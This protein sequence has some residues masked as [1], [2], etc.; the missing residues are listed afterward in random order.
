M[1]IYGPYPPSPG[2]TRWRVQVYD[3]D[4]SRGL[5]L[6]GRRWRCGR[7]EREVKQASPLLVHEAIEQYLEFKRHD[8]RAE[9][10][11]EVL[12]QKL[13][14]ICPNVPV[15]SVTR[16]K[17]EQ[18]YLDETKRA[19]KYGLIRPATHQAR[20]R[21]VKAMWAWM[22][23]REMAV[24]NPWERVEPIGKVSTG[25]QLRRRRR[26]KARQV[27]VHPSGSG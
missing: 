25:K 13:R 21:L 8:I 23:R 18:F 26:A 16:Q 14:Q 24:E 19:G 1:V 2:R 6:R 9:K 4:R 11:V 17:A 5:G 7:T 27:P 12:G 22:I 10:Q 3:R 15:A 20:L